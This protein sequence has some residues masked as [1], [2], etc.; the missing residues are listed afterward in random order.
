MV[1][2]CTLRK[3]SNMKVAIYGRK[4]KTAGFEVFFKTL[5][6]LLDEHHI[7]F[8]LVSSYGKFIQKT[9]GTDYPLCNSTELTPA[10]FTCL[11]SLGGDGTVLD[12]L[13]LIR[14]SE[15][16]VMG[17]NLGRLVSLLTFKTKK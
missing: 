3:P 16:P 4:M 1:S 5:V 6:S 10:H 17:I 15:L 7:E 12:T 14:D 9:Y 13:L 11:I 8:A 2:L